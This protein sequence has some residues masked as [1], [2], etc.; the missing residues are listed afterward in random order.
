[1]G[2][3]LFPLAVDP[4]QVVFSPSAIMVSDTTHR[5]LLS[6]GPHLSAQDQYGL[7]SSTS[8]ACS[9]VDKASVVSLVLCL[10][11]SRSLFSLSL[12]VYW[13]VQ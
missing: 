11:L 7:V 13:F 8:S 4:N 9:S 3:F 12:L 2:F 10:S 1:M 6:G 5:T